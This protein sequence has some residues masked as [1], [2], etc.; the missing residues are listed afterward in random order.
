MVLTSA[1]VVVIG[2]L[3]Y[4]KA[5]KRL[6]CSS[7]LKFNIQ[8]VALSSQLL[9]WPIFDHDYRQCNVQTHNRSRL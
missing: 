8:K 5:G 7:L 6:H 3:Y 4:V 2:K 1:I 9:L